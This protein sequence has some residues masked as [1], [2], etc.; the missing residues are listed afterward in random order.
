MA[1]GTSSE[2]GTLTRSNATPRGFERPGGAGQQGVGDVVIEARFDDE[3]AHAGEIPGIVG[4]VSARFGHRPSSPI[5][6]SYHYPAGPSA[7]N[8]R[9]PELYRASI[10]R[11]A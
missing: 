10:S 4:G 5:Q 11:A 1:E 9:R 6:P 2:P 7:N 8:R 3:H